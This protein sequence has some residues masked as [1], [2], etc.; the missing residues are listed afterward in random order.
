MSDLIGEV[1]L[2]GHAAGSL[3]AA[4]GSTLRDCALA[5]IERFADAVQA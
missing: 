4:R 1:G 5:L 3:L 2:Q